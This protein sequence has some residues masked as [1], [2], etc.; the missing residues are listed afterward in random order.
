[1]TRR[2]P[3]RTSVNV[4][5]IAFATF[6]RRVALAVEREPEVVQPEL[7]VV[8]AEVDG[9]VVDGAALPALKAPP[10]EAVGGQHRVIRERL[11]PEH[12]MPDRVGGVLHA[13]VV[14]LRAVV[15]DQP[16]DDVGGVDT[17]R[18]GGAVR[19]RDRVRREAVVAVG[20]E[21]RQALLMA[22]RPA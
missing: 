11:V 14:E 8:V 13:A 7:P 21:L 17:V 10:V 22:L 9:T 20:G 15:R 5:S 4:T 6:S 1:M 12:E 3:V 18:L 19:V 16:P 2:C